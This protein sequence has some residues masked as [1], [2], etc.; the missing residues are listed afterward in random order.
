MS[1]N[2]VSIPIKPMVLLMIIPFLNGYFIGN[3][4][5]FQSNPWIFH[6]F[7]AIGVPRCMEIRMV[8][9]YFRTHNMALEDEVEVLSQ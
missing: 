8:D 6:N 4:P 2:V 1:E 5:Y 9:G 3:I 7:P